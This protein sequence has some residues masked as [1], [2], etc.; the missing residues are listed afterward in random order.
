MTTSKRDY[1]QVLGVSRSAS[2]EDIKRAFRKLA[3]EYHP[4]RNKDLS[5]GERFKEINEAYQVLSDSRKRSNYD[6]F[7]HAGVQS[8]GGGF[9]GFENFGGFGDI[10]DAFFGGSTRRSARTARQGADLHVELT[11]EFEKAAFGSEEELDVRRHELCSRCRGARSEPGSPPNTC[12][13]CGG[14]G[15]VRR[16]QQGIFGSF[17][18]I[19]PC[20]ACR[21]EGQILT[22]PC[23]NCRGLG[24]ESR[25]RKMAVSIPAGI[26]P[27]TQ[28][29]LTGEG[30][31]GEHGGPPG[32]LYV[33]IR[34]KKHEFFQRQRYDVVYIQHIDIAQAALGLT[35]D[36]PTL[37]G[38]AELEIPAGTQSGE[39]IRLKGQG[40]PHMRNTR[41][42]G[43]QLVTIIVNVPKSLTDEQRQLLTRLSETFGG[44][45]PSGSKRDGW[46]D[47][48]KHT[49]GA[50]E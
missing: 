50:D 39:V 29:R 35:L 44:T 26:E 3:M 11:L 40:I 27:N 34:V 32:D 13:Q 37:D 46:F 28:L 21:G 22:N 42:R 47:K 38:G 25:E 43:D 6:T 9:E 33:A 20:G 41:A 36:V 30:H 15:E 4:D 31:A 10:I 5:A 45:S 19:S 2:D 49:L 17:T 48:L 7:G 12:A 23:S 24:T 1:Y 14:T 18:Q 16:R 8:N